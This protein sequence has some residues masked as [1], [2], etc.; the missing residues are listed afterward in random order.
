MKRYLSA[1]GA[2][3][4][5]AA[6]VVSS[7]LVTAPSAHADANGTL[8]VNLVDQYGHPA[9]GAIEVLSS[10]DDLATTL[11]AGTPASVAAGDYA[12]QA[13]GPWFGYL[14]AGVPSCST[15]ISSDDVTVTPVATVTAGQTKIYTM[16][17]QV[18]AVV[19]SSKVGSTLSVATAP[20]FAVLQAAAALYGSITTQW[21]RNGVAIPGATDT[22]YTTTP[23][24]GSRSISARLTLPA[25][26]AAVFFTEMH[27]PVTPFTTNAVAMG[28]AVKVKTKTQLKLAKSI[29]SGERVTAK[30]RV[31]ARHG[32]A[33]GNV[34]LKVG[35]YK[36]KK[37][38]K[39][40]WL[41]ITLPSLH[42]GRYQVTA[43]YPGAPGF[44]K[45]K[46]KA[47]L[48]VH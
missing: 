36:T 20:G 21:L 10:T 44:A 41:F 1:A 33:T 43:T 19:G 12:F 37:A 32:A 7:L 26:M 8:V 17:V 18:P 30:V 4:A 31:K 46:K 39:K 35:R 38:L 2:F 27:V 9:V 48:S 24:D 42:A 28:K 23:V 13:M 29:R 22:S 47:T 34:V 14:C 6:L 15:G 11:I 3:V 16:N 5:A 40:G 45:S 25:S